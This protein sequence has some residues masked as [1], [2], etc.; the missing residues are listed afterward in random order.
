MPLTCQQLL[1][2]LLGIHAYLFII[3]LFGM[4][5]INICVLLE[6][7]SSNMSHMGSKCGY[8]IVIIIQICHV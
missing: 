3:S 7:L 6:A 2:L 8:N 4:K 1:V 5:V